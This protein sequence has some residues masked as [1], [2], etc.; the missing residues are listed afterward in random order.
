VPVD[1]TFN[2]ERKVKNSELGKAFGFDDEASGLKR[3]EII[4]QEIG[5][6]KSRKILNQMKNKVIE[7]DKIKSASEIKKI[8]KL[9]A[10]EFKEEIQ[11]KEAEQFA[12]EWERKRAFLPDFNLSAKSA[13]KLYNLR[14]IISDEDDSELYLDNLD[15]GY[16]LHYY[17]SNLYDAYDWDAMKDKARVEKKKQLL[18]L[19]Y[20]IKMKKL[21]K[22]DKPLEEV[23]ESL[24]IPM[25]ILRSM[26]DKFYEPI[27][28]K[29]GEQSAGKG[30]KFSKTKALDL[31]LICY[32]L[33]LN[34]IIRDF[35]INLKPLM[36]VLKI[37]E[38][39]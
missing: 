27:K 7:E 28:V 14:S 23:S 12:K 36:K 35:K 19:N 25:T 20:L 17:I 34:L 26:V 29:K 8:I 21:K 33:I 2:F 15:E 22:I 3:K 31:R 30:V 9:Q 6:K 5:T 37:D 18:Y 13:A 24:G 38:P 4:V 11:A 16:N 39:K 1:R 10:G 32:I